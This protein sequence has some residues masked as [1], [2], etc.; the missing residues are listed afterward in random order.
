MLGYREK[1]VGRFTTHAL[2]YSDLEPYDI[3]YIQ[4]LAGMDKEKSGQSTLRLLSGDDQ[5]YSVEYPVERR[6]K[7]ESLETRSAT[8]AKDVVSTTTR[9]SIEHQFENRSWL[10]PID[11][12]AETSREDP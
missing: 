12:S 2:D 4:E 11:E 8:P 5:G 9:I 6:A 10:F 7:Q 3:L 1:K